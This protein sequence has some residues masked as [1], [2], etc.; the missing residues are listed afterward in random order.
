MCAT[1]AKPST[2]FS[3]TDPARFHEAIRRFDEA[4]AVDPNLETHEGKSHPRELLYAV[5]LTEWLLRLRPDADET[6][7]LAARC[8]HICRWM[9]PRDSYPMTRPGYL[10]W[11]QVLK[12]FHAD[13]AGTI[14]REAGYPEETIAK[15]QAL[16][17]KQ[18]LPQD[19]AACVLEDALCLVFLQWQLESVASGMPE[20]KAIAV[21]QKTWKKMTPQ[22][23]AH[24]LQLP[25]PPNLKSL[26]RKATSPPDRPASHH[27]GQIQRGGF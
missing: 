21:L 25:L 23:H 10:K 18:N 6:L 22:G 24:A 13:K 15:V 5:R 12:Q 26:L 17:L 2:P 14:L 27:H 20:E 1:P 9:I 16:N 8:Q 11:R 4:N 7:R 3:L 19:P